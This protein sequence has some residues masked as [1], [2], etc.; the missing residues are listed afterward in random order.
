MRWAQR[1]DFEELR[2]R[3]REARA[4]I[5]S[6]SKAELAVISKSLTGFELGAH[7]L[8]LGARQ[9]HVAVASSTAVSIR[10]TGT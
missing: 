2:G 7:P 3:L 8:G 1:R 10:S 5:S 6:D 4:K 9:A